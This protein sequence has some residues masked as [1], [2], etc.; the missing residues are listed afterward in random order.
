EILDA[1]AGG[2][3]V[4]GMRRSRPTQGVEAG[5]PV[6][7]GGLVRLLRSK[8]TLVFVAGLVVAAGVTA[9]AVSAVTSQVVVVDT[10]S[11]HL[12]TQ[13][14][15]ADGGF[16]TGWHI[17]PGLAIVQVQ[18]GSIQIYENG[19]TA[20]TVSAGDTFIEVPWYPVRGI[21]TGHVVWTT[22][23]VTNGPDPTQIPLTAYAP[24]LNPC[25]TL[26]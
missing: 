22:T 9:V 15:T 16:D 11:L 20:K 6:R 18:Q 19:C 14:S 4:F 1:R 7:K 10:S 8:R 24:G 2:R 3:C 13:V 26:P 23:F 5:D 17:H 12:R 21:G 25:P